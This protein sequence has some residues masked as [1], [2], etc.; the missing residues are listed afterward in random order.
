MKIQTVGQLRE[1]LSKFKDSD[2]LCTMVSDDFNTYGL[3]VDINSYEGAGMDGKKIAFF[4]N[5]SARIDLKLTV[6]A[7]NYEETPML[8]KVTK[9][10]K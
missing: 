10:S 7:D 4:N 2:E 6:G 9:R 5:G 3:D 8:A 1:A